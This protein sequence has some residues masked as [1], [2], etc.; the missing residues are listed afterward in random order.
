MAPYERSTSAIDRHPRPVNT[1]K[2][3]LNTKTEPTPEQNQPV[4]TKKQK[5]SAVETLKNTVARAFVRI[6]M[7]VLKTQSTKNATKASINRTLAN[8]ASRTLLTAFLP[9]KAIQLV[10][11]VTNIAPKAIQT[12]PTA[13]PSGQG[14]QGK[15]IVPGKAV[16]VGPNVTSV[17]QTNQASGGEPRGALLGIALPGLQPGKAFEFGSKPIPFTRVEASLSVQPVPLF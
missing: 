3:V 6:L 12:T 16:K 1:Y 5:R 8:G 9:G 11:N 7:N 17:T 14:E 2:L 15:G 13:Q 10:T 4:E